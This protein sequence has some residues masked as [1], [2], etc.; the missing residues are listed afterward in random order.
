MKSSPPS[1]TITCRAFVVSWMWSSPAVPTIVAGTPSQVGGGSWAWTTTAPVVS[2]AIAATA[3]RTARGARMAPPRSL[4]DDRLWPGRARRST[5]PRCER[6]AGSAA[7]LAQHPLHPLGPRERDVER[8]VAVAAVLPAL[9]L[10][11]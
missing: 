6:T 2:A 5:P 11:V 9:A 3:G 7:R 4:R 8:A 10:L 1:V